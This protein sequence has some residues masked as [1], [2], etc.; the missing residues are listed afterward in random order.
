[1]DERKRLG[2]R[3]GR[4]GRDG[5]DGTD[6]RDGKDGVSRKGDPGQDGQK[7]DK[8]DRGPPGPRPDHRWDG[9]SLQFER[10]DGTWGELVNLEGPPG[11]NGF[12]GGG[13]GGGSGSGSGTVS[14]NNYFPGGWL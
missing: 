2:N 10:A 14:T 6:G 13:G 3:A 9:T 12:V 5:R 11:R 1:M 7:G 4:D 8:G